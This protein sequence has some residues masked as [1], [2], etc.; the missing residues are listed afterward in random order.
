[1]K[2]KDKE[3]KD[4]KSGLI[5]S[6]QCVD[7][8]CSEEYIVETSRTLRQRYKEHPKQ[9]SPIHAHIQKTAHIP[10]TNNLNIIWREDY[11][12]ARTIKEAIYLRVNNPTLNRNTGKYNLNHIWDRVLFNTPGLK[13]D[14]SQNQLH[15]HN[16]G[17]AQ[18]NTAN[19]QSLVVIGH[20]GHTLNS[21]QVF[22]ES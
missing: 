6:Y 11:S 3:P 13:L 16:N 7:I 17:Q 2:P 14:S 12:L 19:N 21:E 15:L 5:Y 9:P 22:R 8:A 4:Q 10:T 18:T 20:S 1:M